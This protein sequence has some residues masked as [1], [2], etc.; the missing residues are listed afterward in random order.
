M[1]RQ[2][3]QEII[4][5]T[6]ALKTDV[7]LTHE[8]VTGNETT[9]VEVSPGNKVR[10]PKKMIED[11]Y[12][13]TQTEINQRFGSLEQAVGDA[14]TQ[15]DR[16]EQQAGLAETSRQSA[17]RRAADSAASANAASVSQTAAAGSASTAQTAATNAATSESRAASSE[18]SAAGSAT[19]ASS[20]KNAASQSQSSAAGSATTA[21][22]SAT[23]AQQAQT[24]AEQARDEVLP[25]APVIS[26]L[27]MQ[28]GRKN[29]LING[30]FAINQRAKTEYTDDD[31]CLDRWRMWSGGKV[32]QVVNTSPAQ[33]EFAV[34]L[35]KITSEATFYSFIQHIEGA[36]NHLAGKQLTLSFY[37]RAN[38]VGTLGALLYSHEASRSIASADYAVTDTWEHRGLTFTTYGKQNASDLTL[39]LYLAEGV[40]TLLTDNGN[41]LEFAAVQLEIGE[42]ATEFETVHPGTELA[43]C[44]RYYCR[45]YSPGIPSGTA[46]WYGHLVRHHGCALSTGG[47]YIDGARFP[48]PMRITP[49][50]KIYNPRSGASGTVDEFGESHAVSINSANE[51]GFVIRAEDSFLADR[52]LSFQFEASAEI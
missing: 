33:T 23:A 6:D 10:S 14:T 21:Q 27:Q 32:Q 4:E 41:W 42:T 48:L 35:T 24:E 34:R 40:N 3:D 9:V 13:E 50:I 22:T 2:L 36:I 29:L 18:T 47:Y 39:T 51:N 16:A 12:A 15:A 46:D 17:D 30:D 31:Y 28:G 44:Q 25:L 19:S 7:E 38:K 43:L 37:V 11:A 20:S 49:T 26:Q 1:A 5:A 8:I 52:W 45:S